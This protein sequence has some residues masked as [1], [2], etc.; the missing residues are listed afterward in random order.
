MKLQFE[1][2]MYGLWKAKTFL[3][4]MYPDLMRQ[5]LEDKISR[6]IMLLTANILGEIMTK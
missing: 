1:N 4:I 5:M 6:E 3:T 2:D